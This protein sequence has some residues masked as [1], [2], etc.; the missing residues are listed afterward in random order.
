MP[1][2]GVR[3]LYVDDDPG[4]S[5]LVE[6]ALQKRGFIVEQASGPE[7]AMARIRQGGIDAVGLDHYMPGGT[8]LDVLSALKGHDDPPPVVYVTSSGDTSVAVTALKE[9]AADYVSKDVA[10]DFL[11]LLGSA[12]EGAIRQTRLRREKAAA[13]EAVREQRDRAEALLREVNH[14]VGNSLSLVGALIRIQANALSDPAAIAALKETQSRIN[15]IAAVHKQLYTTEDV[16]TINVGAFVSSLVADL[17]TAM[18]SEGNTAR[19]HVESD[20]CAVPADKAIPLG[21][22]V[23]ELV[24]NAYKYAYP[25]GE[26]GEIRVFVRCLH[27]TATLIVEDDGVGM[28]KSAKPGGTGIGGQIVEAMATTL[29][30][31]FELDPAHK[32]TRAVLEFAI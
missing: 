11:E 6:K 3:V 13:E 14:R 12:I 4:I 5:R 8:G 26:E 24:T 25:E 17:Q 1:D 31:R 18:R 23:S 29:K 2:Q 10:G 21:V 27:G 16:R 19:T 22:V 7:D 15:A 28:G 9:G 30:A 32:G 20:A